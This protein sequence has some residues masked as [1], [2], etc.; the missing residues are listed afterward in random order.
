M[1][2]RQ[3]TIEKSTD[4]SLPGIWGIN[5]DDGKSY[6]YFVN[7]ARLSK[8]GINIEEICEYIRKL[9]MDVLLDVG[10]G[11]SGGPMEQSKGIWV[12]G[13]RETDGVNLTVAILKLREMGVEF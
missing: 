11:Q 1:G 6:M 3:E 10:F 7:A 5:A 13:E 2:I 12:N 4:P 8:A 9:G